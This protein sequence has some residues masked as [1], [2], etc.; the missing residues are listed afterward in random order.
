MGFDVPYGNVSGATNN[1][2]RDIICS[3]DSLYRAMKISS[4]NLMWKDSVSGWVANGIVNCTKLRNELLNDE[5]QI[6]QY[7][8]FV[9]YEPKRR[10]IVSTRFKDR[11]F[12]RSMCDNYL[13]AEISKGFIYDNGACL[14]NKGTE[15]SRK[16]LRAHL[17]QFYRQHGTEGYVLKCDI[18]NYFGSTEHD[19][20]SAAVIKRVEDEWVRRKTEDIIQSFNQGPN[21]D[22]GMGLGSQV[23]QLIQLAVLDDLDHIIKEKFKIKHYVRY[24]DDFILIH[25]S[26][27]YLEEC[28]AYIAHWMEERKLSLNIKKTQIFPI[29]QRIRF[30]GFSYQL[31][32]T[33]YVIIRVLPEKVKKKKRKLKRLVDRYDRGL[34]TKADVDASYIAFRT[35]LGFGDNRNVIQR[36]DTFYY[37]LWRNYYERK[38]LEQNSATPACQSKDKNAPSN[39]RKVES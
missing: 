13:T 15:F 17:Q 25:E 16:R 31:T 7:T 30:L 18:K 3:F 1:S 6:S 4:Q 28:R 23:T 34:M 19:L 37:H 29:T 5:Y 38:A 36:F 27:E 2:P 33:G 26:K 10:E 9:I 39:Q 24:M 8:E 21:P 32:D 12:Q 11:V 35:Y 14:N 22:I 20:A